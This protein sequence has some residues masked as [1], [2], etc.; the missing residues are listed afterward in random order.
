[1]ADPRAKVRLERLQKAFERNANSKVVMKMVPSSVDDGFSAKSDADKRAE[2][3]E[4]LKALGRTVFLPG[5]EAPPDLM[6]FF[7]PVLK[8]V[9][10]EFGEERVVESPMDAKGRLDKTAETPGLDALADML[11]YVDPKCLD[12]GVTRKQERALKAIGALKARFVAGAPLPKGRLYELVYRI[13]LSILRVRRVAGCLFSLTDAC[14]G[15]TLSVDVLD[16]TER[17]ENLAQ[18]AI[19]LTWIRHVM[20][21]T[22]V[23]STYIACLP[24]ADKQL[25]LVR[26]FYKGE[27]KNLRNEELIVVKTS[28]Y[29][30]TMVTQHVHQGTKMRV[31]S[32]DTEDA[33]RHL[34]EMCY[35]IMRVDGTDVAAQ[36]LVTDVDGEIEKSAGRMTEL[37]SV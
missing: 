4:A 30:S 6:P 27:L 22:D 2:T 33:L 18:Q 32:V 28:R 11:G 13:T 12:V 7:T 20:R 19:V 5:E 29:L 26:E 14:L 25:K 8:A 15:D 24:K 37:P 10:M 16:L 36:A 17:A 23:G 1:M 35:D 9:L 21:S 3:I 34:V 31:I